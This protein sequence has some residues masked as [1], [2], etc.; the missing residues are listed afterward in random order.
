MDARK[1]YAMA[2]KII[3]P[4]SLPIQ[5]VFLL[6]KPGSVDG[7]TV[8]RFAVLEYISSSSSMSQLFDMLRSGFLTVFGEWCG[9]HVQKN[10]ALSKLPGNVF[11]VFSM[12]IGMPAKLTLCYKYIITHARAC[13]SWHARIYNRS[14]QIH[15]KWVTCIARTH[16]L[17][18]SHYFAFRR[19]ADRRP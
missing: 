18:L 17:L 7:L 19:S 16:T 12:Q 9:A 11:C 2:K 10:V 1:C 5:R 6:L 14:L 4:R 8:F 3:P 15:S 13:A